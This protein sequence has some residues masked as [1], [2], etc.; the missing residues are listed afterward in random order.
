MG[1]LLSMIKVNKVTPR[2]IKSENNTDY[3][4][5]TI[6]IVTLRVTF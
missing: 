1:W 6:K 5:E 3:I 2:V 4:P